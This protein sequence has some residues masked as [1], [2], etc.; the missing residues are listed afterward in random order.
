MTTLA[1]NLALAALAL[2]VVPSALFAFGALG[3]TP[4]KIAMMAGAVLWFA[5]SPFWLKGG[6]E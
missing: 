5:A 4:M 2:T 3:D 6:K 1:R